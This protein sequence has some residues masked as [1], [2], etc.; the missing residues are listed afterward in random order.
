MVV[1][2]RPFLADRILALGEDY[3]DIEIVARAPT[4]RAAIVIASFREPQVVLIEDR[5][6]DANAF[7]VCDFIRREFPEVA[8]ILVSEIQTDAMSLLAVEA[9]A[10]GLISRLAPDQD[11]ILALLRAADGE[12]LLPRPVTLR[13]FRRERDLRLQRL[14][15][16]DGGAAG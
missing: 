2:D 1:E 5:L 8:V 11:L 6:S 15:H 4:G 10:C 14:P 7:Q 3:P 9:G 12:F 13:L 16:R